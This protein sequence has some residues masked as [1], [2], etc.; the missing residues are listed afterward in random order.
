M[1]KQL[2]SLLL[3]A[4]MATSLLPATAWAEAANAADSGAAQEETIPETPPQEVPEVPATMAEADSEEPLSDTQEEPAP[5]SDAQEEE[6]APVEDTDSV[7]ASGTCGKDGDNLTW[8][9]DDQGTLTITGTGE[10][11]DYSSGTAPWYDHASAIK[12][13]TIEEG[14]TSVGTCA[15]S[16]LGITDVSLADSIVLIGYSAFYSVEELKTLIL[17]KGLI[18]IDDSAFS[19]CENLSDISGGQNLFIIGNYAF[20]DCCALETI[21]FGSKVD[22]IGTGAFSYCSRLTTAIFQGNAPTTFGGTATQTGVFADVSYTFTIFYRSGTTGWTSPTWNGYPAVCRDDVATDF[23]TL[24]SDNR[25]VQGIYFQLNTTA[26]TA[27][28]GKNTTADNNAGYAGGQNGSIVI[29]DTVT[30]GESTYTVIGINQYAFANCAWINTISLGKNI[31]SVEPSA[32]RGCKNL[33]A[34]TVSPDNLQFAD[35]DGVLFD[36]CGL[37]LYAY[38]AGRTDSTYTIPDSCNTVGTMSFSDAVN[39]TSI[40]VPNSVKNIG[41]KAFAQCNALEEATLP[42]IGGNAESTAGAGFVFNGYEY[43]YNSLPASLKRITVYGT[44]IP[45]QAFRWCGNLE[46]IYLPDC[47]ALTVIPDSCFSQCSSLHTLSFDGNAPSQ[48]GMIMIPDAVVTIESSAFESCKSIRGVTLGKSATNLPHAVF[49]NCV[50]IERFAVAKGNTSFMADQWGVLYSADQTTL[51]YYPSGRAWPYYNVNAA[52][53][54]IGTYAFTFCNNLVNLF[55]PE[56]VTSFQTTGFDPCIA[57]CP[58]TTICCYMGSPIARYAIENGLTPWYMDNYALQ[59]I[60]VE[61]LPEYVVVDT[62]GELLNAPYVTATYGDKKLQLDDYEVQFASISGKQAL[63]FMSGNVSTEVEANVLRRG[64][65]N[66]DTTAGQT[67]ID[68][69][70]MQCLYTYLTTGENEGKVTDTAYFDLVSD[71]NGDGFIDV[72]DLQR[73]YEAVSGVTPF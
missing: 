71:I 4:I 59:G 37:Y 41:A 52:T 28:V 16:R 31:S 15:F 69:S 51:C 53:T 44:N 63:T 67:D 13:V 19:N 9:L 70:D 66:G 23:S 2:I 39:L 33:T 57:N 32:F 3:A 56:S 47:H 55:V 35:Q 58:G 54:C 43:N 26:M 27:T 18:G 7:I 29:P 68:A 6:P 46:E 25:N 36:K 49:Y 5:L 64:N 11:K 40:S 10:M 24:D 60:T 48:Y 42:F 12:K 20:S 17:P 73:L 38:P 1:K 21:E 34:I 45:R 8:T 14:V 22:S 30:K 61:G 72:Y 62:D 65:V 50:G